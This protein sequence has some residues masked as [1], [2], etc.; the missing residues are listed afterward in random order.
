MTSAR[1]NRYYTP[2]SYDAA[3]AGEIQVVSEETWR[4]EARSQGQV[5]VTRMVESD[6]ALVDRVLKEAGGRQNILVINDEAHHAY[7]IP[8]K[9]DDRTT[10]N[11]TKTRRTQKKRKPAARRRRSGSMGWTRSPSSAESISASI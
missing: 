1:G 7:R 6:A 8:P 3:K 2:D 5:Y 11:R 4:A 10:T 9:A